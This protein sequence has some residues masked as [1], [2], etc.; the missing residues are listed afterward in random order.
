M[1]D[2]LRR[3][4]PS[5]VRFTPPCGGYYIWLE[6]PAGAD[7]AAIAREGPAS[8]VDFRPGP[9]FSCAGSWRNCLR[10][11]FTYHSEPKLSLAAE[12]LAELLRAHL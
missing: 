10:L 2:C 4:L 7:A 9:V 3:V 5:Q 12:R 11:C 1:S 6:L 8:G